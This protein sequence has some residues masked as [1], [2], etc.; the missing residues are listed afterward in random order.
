ME[1]T[2]LDQLF[3]FDLFANNPPPHLK[4]IEKQSRFYLN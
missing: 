1:M 2:P 4:L 3:T